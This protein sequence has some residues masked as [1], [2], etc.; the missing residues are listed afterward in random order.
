MVYMTNLIKVTNTKFSVGYIHYLPF[1]EV[2]GLGK[3][4]DELQATGLLVEQLPTPENN[5]K[6]AMLY[7]NPVTSTFFYEYTELQKTSAQEMAEEIVV[8]KAKLETQGTRLIQMEEDSVAFQEFV[9][10]GM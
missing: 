5:G 2:H 10:G 4:V 6:Q 1:D 9:L 7:V 3:T 8:L